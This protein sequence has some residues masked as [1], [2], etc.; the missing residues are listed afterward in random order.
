MISEVQLDWWQ[1][2]F[3]F[4][5]R[6]QFKL[7]TDANVRVAKLLPLETKWR[8]NSP[9]VHPYSVFVVSDGVSKSF[10]T[11]YIEK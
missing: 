10:R 3:E 8:A 5:S 7:P 9:D 6:R 4:H 11:E 1:T 2:L